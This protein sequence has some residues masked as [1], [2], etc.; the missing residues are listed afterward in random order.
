MQVVLDEAGAAP[1]CSTLDPEGELVVGRPEAVYFYSPD[2]RGP[3]FVFE[4]V[5]WLLPACIRSPGSLLL[6]LLMMRV[7]C[8]HPCYAGRLVSFSGWQQW[9]V[10]SP[11]LAQDLYHNLEC[12]TSWT[13]APLIVA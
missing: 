7:P 9:G 12:D 10:P 2:G 3:C 1:G 8:T 11:I 5:H 4:G 13:E 6:L